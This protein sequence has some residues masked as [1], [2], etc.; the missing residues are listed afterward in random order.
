MSMKCS[1]V[2]DD[3]ESVN[4]DL[5]SYQKL[6]HRPVDYV[7]LYATTIPKTSDNGPIIV[8]NL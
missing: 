6:N 3:H 7:E 8:Y 5:T 4:E 2:A 1:A